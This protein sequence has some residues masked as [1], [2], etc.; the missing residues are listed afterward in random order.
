[1]YSPPPPVGGIV[2]TGTGVG[3][4]AVV[5][6]GTVVGAVVGV[7]VGFF[8][9]GL[10]VFVGTAGGVVAVGAAVAVF[11]GAVV[12]VGIAVLVAVAP[13]GFGGGP[14]GV[15][16]NVGGG[17]GVLAAPNVCDGECIAMPTANIPTVAGN[18]N[19]RDK[20]LFIQDSLR[21]ALLSGRRVPHK[22]SAVRL[23][24]RVAVGLAIENPYLVGPHS[25]Q[26]REESQPLLA[27]FIPPFA[28]AAR[29][30]TGILRPQRLHHT[31]TP[32][33]CQRNIHLLFTPPS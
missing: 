29:N 11:V 32:S 20:R 31:G 22:N 21:S 18:A 23:S 10:G 15:G 26:I 24:L 6:T 25:N 7:A 27:L 17:G 2:A 8:F 4:G 3:T 12:A 19:P 13:G 16:I 28:Y 33:R 5:A 9:V 14:I 1:M 30:V